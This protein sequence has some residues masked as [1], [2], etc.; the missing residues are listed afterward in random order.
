MQNPGTRKNSNANTRDQQHNREKETPQ[1]PWPE[2]RGG[3][4]EAK[5]V[6]DARDKTTR[7]GE[8]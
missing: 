4:G 8:R 5:G 1:R 3:S 6:A 2:G 7:S